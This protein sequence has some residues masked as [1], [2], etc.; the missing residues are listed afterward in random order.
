MNIYDKT[1]VYT[2]N[3]EEFLFEFKTSLRA[4]EKVYFI[5]AVSNLLIDD[6]YNS[7][8]RDLIFDFFIVDVFTNVDTSWA[9]T[10]EDDEEDDVEKIDVISEM[11]DL[12]SETNIVEI[13]TMNAEIGLIDELRNALD[14]N[15]E[16]RTGI[17]KNPISE[18][19]A[20]LINTLDRKIGNF[21]MDTES[22]MDMMNM[23]SG[24]SGELTADK[25]L[26]A[27]SKSDMYKKHND[28]LIEKREHHNAVIDEIIKSNNT[29]TPALS[30]T[31]EV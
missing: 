16:Y 2:R 26:E 20:N 4:G 27:Y 10:N 21:N 23:L 11:E 14:L 17:H 12:I 8:L 30:P 25:M 24:I 15:I 29:I 13:V 31:Y 19:L 1:G 9:F 22:M 3:G 18:S 6:N 28:E 5:N 7:V